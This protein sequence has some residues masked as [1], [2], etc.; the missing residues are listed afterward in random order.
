MKIEFISHYGVISELTATDL[1]DF[2]VLI[3]PNG[4]GKSH[5]F[6]CLGHW[7]LGYIR[8]DQRGSSAL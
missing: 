2:A 6:R 5:V 3:G 7:R 4:A 8:Y 1:P